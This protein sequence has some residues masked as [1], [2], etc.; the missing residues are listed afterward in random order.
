[1]AVALRNLSQPQ[2]GYCPFARRSAGGITGTWLA[3]LT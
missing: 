2:R 1:V 3:F